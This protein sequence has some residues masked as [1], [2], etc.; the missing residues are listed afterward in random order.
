MRVKLSTCF[1]YLQYAYNV[2]ILILM[3]QQEELCDEL[4]PDTK[5]GKGKKI[6]GVAVAAV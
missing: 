5:S 4:T 3:N 6:A 1:S 2:N